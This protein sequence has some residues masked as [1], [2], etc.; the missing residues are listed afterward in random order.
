MYRLEHDHRARIAVDQEHLTP[1]SC[2]PLL[3]DLPTRLKVVLLLRFD[4]GWNSREISEVFKCT[5]GRIRQLIRQ[6]LEQLIT[7]IE[8]H[9]RI[10]Q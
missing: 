2:H 6:G 10:S 4:E 5:H 7:L 3:K 8:E 9:E 1:P